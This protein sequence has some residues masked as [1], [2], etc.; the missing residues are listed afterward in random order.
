MCCQYVLGR[1]GPRH[2]VAWPSRVLQAQRGAKSDFL[3]TIDPLSFFQFLLIGLLPEE[4]T[5]LQSLSRCRTGATGSNCR[6]E[7]S[8]PLAISGKNCLPCGETRIVIRQLLTAWR[9]HNAQ[10]GRRWRIESAI[11][12]TRE[13]DPRTRL[14][15]IFKR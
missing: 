15:G 10:A 8:V 2:D 12:G 13:A 7:T 9:W 5:T 6:G 1:Y 14:L 3:L 4:S 11:A